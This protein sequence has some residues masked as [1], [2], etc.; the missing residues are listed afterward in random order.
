M[1]NS[2]VANRGV[3]EGAWSGMCEALY[4][5]TVL[6]SLLWWSAMEQWS[7]PSIYAPC[8]H[9]CLQPEEIF[10]SMNCKLVDELKENKKNQVGERKEEASFCQ[11]SATCFWGIDNWEINVFKYLGINNLTEKRTR[12]GICYKLPNHIRDQHDCHPK[13]LLYARKIKA[14]LLKGILVT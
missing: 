10:F 2:W 1:K 12:Q 7:W 11:H 3:L 5:G 13:H 14:L 8:F 6:H 4:L 9:S